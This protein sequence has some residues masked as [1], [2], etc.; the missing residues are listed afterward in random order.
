[1]DYRGYKVKETTAICAFDTPR[2]MLVWGEL[3]K[4][5]NDSPKV[6]TVSARV[7]LDAGVFALTTTGAFYEHCADIAE[8][9]AQVNGLRNRANLWH[10]NAQNEHNAAVA[11]HMENAKLKQ[12]IAEQET[13]N[14]KLKEIKD[15]YSS[16]AGKAIDRIAKCELK[17]RS[18][19]RALFKACAN[20]ASSERYT[21]ATWHG[22]EHREE[23]WAE[24]QHKCLKKAEEYK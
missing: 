7:R 16:C 8:L 13:E 23:L 10:Y 17:I 1:M 2:K 5:K 24:V 12:K 6:D 18:L 15:K 4:G 9:N 21:E 14:R 11:V 19:S 20:W 3:G 22:D